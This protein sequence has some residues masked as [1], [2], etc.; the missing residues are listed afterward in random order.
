MNK[1]LKGLRFVIEI[2]LVYLCYN[3]VMSQFHKANAF[4]RCVISGSGK[5]AMH[6]LEKLLS[7]GAIP[8]T[9]SGVQN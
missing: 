2:H 3:L 7:C 9:V 6:V 5:I 8:V 4:C 1:E